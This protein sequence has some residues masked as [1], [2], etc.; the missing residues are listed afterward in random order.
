MLDHIFA[1]RKPNILHPLRLQLWKP[2]ADTNIYRR[3]V[4][5]N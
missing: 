4:L 5:K 1:E 2:C 3:C